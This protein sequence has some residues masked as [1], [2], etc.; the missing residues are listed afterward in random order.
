MID[1]DKVVNWELLCIFCARDE[2][3]RH[4]AKRGCTIYGLL[5]EHAEK[6]E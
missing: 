5:K 6:R 2:E 1:G 3:Y 4:R